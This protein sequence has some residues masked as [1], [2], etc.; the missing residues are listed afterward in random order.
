L[1]RVLPLEGKI[2]RRKPFAGPKA[3]GSAKFSLLIVN[4]MSG[5]A[6]C[7]EK[8]S[9]MKRSVVN[10]VLTFRSFPI[11]T[12]ITNTLIIAVDAEMAQ[13]ETR[14]LC[15]MENTDGRSTGFEG[16]PPV[17]VLFEKPST[18]IHHFASCKKSMIFFRRGSAR[19]FGRKR[20]GTEIRSMHPS[21]LT[22]IH[23]CSI[24]LDAEMEIHFTAPLIYDSH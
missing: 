5:I 1:I 20:I 7:Q 23:P 22:D 18:V 6:G 16:I 17:L 19:N 9:R 2:L 3:D 13:P 12:A 15:P 8:Q 11:E 24:Y 4:I 21:R 10:Q 14:H